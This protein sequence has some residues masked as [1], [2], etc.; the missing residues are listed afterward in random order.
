M[1]WSV[2]TP[3]WVAPSSSRPRVQRT[4]PRVAPTSSP[5]AFRRDGTAKKC[6]NS[7][8]VP[9]TRWT[10]TASAGRARGPVGPD[11]VDEV[12]GGGHGPALRADLG[13]AEDGRTAPSLDPA[14]GHGVLL[15][16]GAE[17]LH[18]HR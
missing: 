8:Y 10:R 1:T 9:S 18:V 4:T 7:S 12:P 11:A 14:L 6:R 17:V 15:H 2:A 3:T 13:S 5:A 16:D